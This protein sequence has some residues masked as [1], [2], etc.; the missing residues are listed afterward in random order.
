MSGLRSWSAKKK[1]E[2]D[3]T[4]VEEFSAPEKDTDLRSWS[5]SSK[6]A[7]AEAVEDDGRQK[8]MVL[9]ALQNDPSQESVFKQTGHSNLKDT[10][11]KNVKKVQKGK[12]TW[13]KVR[14][15]R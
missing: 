1:V 8:S 5:K 11:V 9:S 7:P 15:A 12:E 6:V 10:I 4:K 14:D 2:S 3:T 13:A